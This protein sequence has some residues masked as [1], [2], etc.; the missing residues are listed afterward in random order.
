MGT[1]SGPPGGIGGAGLRWRE[2]M[3][4]AMTEVR[5]SGCRSAK[6]ATIRA[7]AA[8]A[9][10]AAVVTVR[11]AAG[12]PAPLPPPV[13]PTAAQAEEPLRAGDQGEFPP[14]VLTDQP[15]EGGEL[16]P[17]ESEVGVTTIR[18]FKDER[19]NRTRRIFYVPNRPPYAAQPPPGRDSLL[20]YGTEVCRYDANGRLI[21]LAN[22]DGDRRL[23]SWREL[24]YWPDG[25]PKLDQY[26][27]Y[28]AG[29]AVVV[30]Q[31]RFAAD[32]DRTNLMWDDDGRR[33]ISISGLVPADVDL[34]EGWGPVGE[35]LQ[36]GIVSDRGSGPGGKTGALGVYLSIKNVSETVQALPQAE[37][38]K[39][40]RPELID[41]AGRI[42]PYDES[43]VQGRL[44]TTYPGPTFLAPNH[45]ASN[46]YAL[47]D[48]YGKI[49]P[50][51]YK[52]LLRRAGGQF[53]LVSNT[54]AVDIMPPIATLS[55]AAD[56]LHLEVEDQEGHLHVGIHPDRVIERGVSLAG[57]TSLTIEGVTILAKGGRAAFI[58]PASSW[59]ADV[60][61]DKISLTAADAAGTMR[62]LQGERFQ[63][64]LRRG[65]VRLLPENNPA[66]GAIPENSKSGG[67]LAN[68]NERTGPV[69][70]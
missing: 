38:V 67:K 4:K 12:A 47:E 31:R 15:A 34:A 49:P 6:A 27:Q 23:F 35:G 8:G 45:A 13:W 3:R 52:L 43:K 64:E 39:L 59:T 63:F 17:V 18:N 36:C 33:L 54:V 65:Q 57:G 2:Q 20:E 24:S 56:H 28:A 37:V 66:E 19:G 53:D 51:H 68:P 55:V 9:I 14:R 41:A 44:K 40:V 69:G 29:R 11:G 26:Y 25:K 1:E 7:V 50:G 62:R 22:Y 21:L 5:V 70:R 32:G 61:R 58:S 10:I 30:T 16:Q 48:W 42:V 46:F 60:A